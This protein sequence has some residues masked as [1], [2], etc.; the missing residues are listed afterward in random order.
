MK[1]SIFL[2]M[3][4]PLVVQAQL[5]EPYRFQGYGG[6]VQSDLST[7]DLIVQSVYKAKGQYGEDI[8][9]QT[10]VEIPT[11]SLDSAL[12]YVTNNPTLLN[13]E[14]MKNEFADVGITD[15]DGDGVF[16]SAHVTG[17]YLTA[18]FT[19][20]DLSP[21]SSLSASDY[22]DCLS[23]LAAYKVG[24]GVISFEPNIVS[25]SGGICN[26]IVNA[27]LNDVLFGR[28]IGTKSTGG[29]ACAYSGAISLG[30]FDGSPLLGYLPE[31]SRHAILGDTLA[32]VAL[33]PDYLP[34]E[35]T[36]KGDEL[37]FSIMTPEQPC[38]DSAYCI[39]QGY[40]LPQPVYYRFGYAFYPAL[41]PSDGPS[42]SGAGFSCEEGSTELACAS[43]DLSELG[44][45]EQ[46]TDEQIDEVF[47]DPFA[48]YTIEG[49][50]ENAAVTGYGETAVCP[51]PY[52]IPFFGNTIEVDTI[53]LCDA[54]SEYM[55]PII[56]FMAWAA[57]LAIV[58]GV[59]YS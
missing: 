38:Y 48:E 25:G 11:S 53:V 40:A 3:L 19:E 27:Y 49:Q 9:A 12:N 13:T 14:Y 52:E 16:D 33:L 47:L 55:N 32:V 10:T 41:L 36:D 23:R 56:Q 58:A 24:L 22:D 57:G 44:E 15:M 50:L 6:P 46:L 43:T 42:S 20:C 59:K 8:F 21:G 35:F 51:E 5:I 30:T 26:L 1:Y 37:T 17:D 4:C 39:Y 28:A 7:D 18:T 45:P 34:E 2:L 29:P 54:F 31:S